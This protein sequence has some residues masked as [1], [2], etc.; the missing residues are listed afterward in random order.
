SKGIQAHI[1]SELRKD[2]QTEYPD[3]DRDEVEKIK[4]GH[5]CDNSRDE[6]ENNSGDEESDQAFKDA[7]NTY[8]NLT[9]L[10]DVSVAAGVL[11]LVLLLGIRVAGLVANRSR[12]ILF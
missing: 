11:G 12:L 8:A 10:G 5:L 4:L 2:I 6:G 9:L 7:C 3:L 1:D